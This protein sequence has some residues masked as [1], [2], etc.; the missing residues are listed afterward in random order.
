MQCE[1]VGDAL[2]AVVADGAGSALHSEEGAAVAVAAI[3]RRMLAAASGPESEWVDAL[4]AAIADARDEI[5]ALANARNEPGNSFATTVLAVVATQG[6]GAYAQLG[7]GLIAVRAKDEDWC[8]A[9][10]PQ[11]GEFANTTYFLTDADALDRLEIDTIRPGVTDIALMTDGLEALAIDYGRGA[12]H[13][14]F[15]KALF[16]PLHA[17]KASGLDTDFSARAQALIQ[18][19]RVTSRV[20]DDITLI[21]ATRLHP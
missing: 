16:A 1:H 13:T 4:R 3:T 8:F 7:D 12:L 6:G 19:P 11:R 14:P 18:S 2:I 9:F 20:D 17:S 21:V 15:F 5:I 10:W